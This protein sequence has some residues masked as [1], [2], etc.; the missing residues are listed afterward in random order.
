MT[1]TV[2]GMTSWPARSPKMTATCFI[3]DG[4][5]GT[6]GNE[7]L[8]PDCTPPDGSAGARRRVVDGRPADRLG[9]PRRV[10]HPVAVRQALQPPAPV[11][12]PVVRYAQEPHGLD[13]GLAAPG[14]RELV[15]ALRPLGRPIAPRPHA[16]A[17]TL[18]QRPP[19]LRR[20]RPV[21]ATHVQRIALAIDQ[22]RRHP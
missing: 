6:C 18:R 22:D 2:F 10:D 12:L 8:A 16:P 5:V 3:M 7:A 15:V 14:P 11:Q 1:L 13:L 20:R 4:S 17:V 9:W 21:P 19:H